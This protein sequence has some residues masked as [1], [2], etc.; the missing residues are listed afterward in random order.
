MGTRRVV[1]G[2]DAGGRP[3]VLSDEEAPVIFESGALPGYE[4]A[5]ICRTESVPARLDQIRTDRRE[6]EFEPKAGSLAWRV[7]VRPPESSGRDLEALLD[8]VGAAGGRSPGEAGG[9][10]GGGMHQTGTVDWLV[11]LSGEVWLTVG[12]GGREVHLGPGDCIVQGGVPHAWHNRGTEPCVMAGLM[13]S[14]VE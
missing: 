7:V 2:F 1:T 5:E 3:A 14:L 11:V 10:G 9:T 6:W 13:I 12:D 4:I 8:E